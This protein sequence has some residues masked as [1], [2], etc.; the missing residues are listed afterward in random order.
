MKPRTRSALNLALLLATVAS[1]TWWTLP[2]LGGEA[3]SARVVMT[4]A[5]DPAQRPQRI[6]MTPVAR[7]FGTPAA[8]PAAAAK[9][10]LVGVIAEGGRG[11]G[12]AVLATDNL[13]AQAYRVGDAVTA[14]L[15]LSAVRSDGVTLT[16]Q[17][18]AEELALP[19]TP[20]PQGITPA[21]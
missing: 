6:D 12:V 16:G 2:W 9:T 8:G 19:P 13:P 14:T 21:R 10:R 17:S 15:T 4:P 20:A 3:S 5:A 11:R 7:L 1:A 18:G